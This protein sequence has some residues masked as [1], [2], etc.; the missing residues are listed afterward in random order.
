[1]PT[2]T[3]HQRTLDRLK[4]ILRRD[5]KLGP[6]LPIPNDMP[7]IGSSMDLDSLDM[8]LLVTHIEK[9]FGVKIPSQAMGHT[10]F[11]NVETLANY[12]ESSAPV[13]RNVPAATPPPDPLSHLPHQDPFRFVTAITHVNPGEAATGIWSLTGNEPFFAGHFP[14]RPIV[15]GVLIAEALAQLSGLVSS[16]GTPR[17]GMLAHLDVRFERPVVPPAQIVLES[18]LTKTVGAAQMFDVTAKLADQ[19]VCR[20]ALALHWSDASPDANRPDRNGK[21]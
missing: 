4:E 9:E 19:V 2:N 5:L 10:V 17:T 3:S 14:G 1:M 13:V 6:D 15:P 8:L 18:R 21:P 12:V 7:L 16:V 20:G 11:E